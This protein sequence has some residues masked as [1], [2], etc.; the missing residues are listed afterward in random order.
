MTGSGVE[1]RV[2]IV[3]GAGAGVG[4]GVAK[5]LSGAGAKVVVAEWKP[6]KMD[7][8]VGEIEQAGGE[9][10][11]V[12]TNVADKHSIKNMVDATIER[13]RRV[14]GLVNNAMTISPYCPIA[15]LSDEAFDM[16]LTSGAKGTLWAMQAVYP[17]MKRAGWGRIVN[18]GSAAGLVSF[19]GMAAY[20]AAKEAIRSL[21]RTAAREWAHDGIVVN[22]YCPIST[23]HHYEA[24]AANPAPAT[25]GLAT[26]TDQYS[27]EAMAAATALSPAGYDGDAETD[28]GPVVEFLLSDACRYLTGQTLTL[29]G[30]TWIH[31]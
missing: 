19:K 27:S 15:E 3:T 22:L 6:D 5:H 12:E 14:D 21:T 13:F 10:L 16:D 4:R 30:G 8:V 11:G 18:V 28:L 25:E 29:D 17:H 20:G 1:G 9:C 24:A 23:R 2:I 31:A 7:A 26:I